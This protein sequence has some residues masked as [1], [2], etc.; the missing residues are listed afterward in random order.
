MFAKSLKSSGFDWTIASGGLRLYQPHSMLLINMWYLTRSSIE[1]VQFLSIKF[2]QHMNE[3]YIL[4]QPHAWLDC[5]CVRSACS[6]AHIRAFWCPDECPYAVSCD[7]CAWMCV[8]KFRTDSDGPFPGTA[9]DA[10]IYAHPICPCANIGCRRCRMRTAVRPHA[11]CCAPAMHST[12][13]T[14]A[15]TPC[16]CSA[17]RPDALAP[18]A[19]RGSPS[20]WNAL[21]KNHTQ[22]AW[23]R[24]AAVRGASSGSCVWIAFR[25]HCIRMFCLRLAFPAS[26]HSGRPPPGIVY[27]SMDPGIACAAF[28]LHRNDCRPE[29][30]HLRC[31]RWCQ[32]RARFWLGLPSWMHRFSGCR[33]DVNWSV[34]E[35]VAKMF[36]KNCA[37]EKAMDKQMF[38]FDWYERR[39]Q[40]VYNNRID[41][42]KKIVWHR[43]VPMDAEYV[44]G[45]SHLWDNTLW[46]IC[47]W[48]TCISLC[49]RRLSWMCEFVILGNY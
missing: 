22:A 9:A 25:T 38:L 40:N 19:W 5:L 29:Y 43:Q 1:I 2:E 6:S 44:S 13:W 21:R 37:A 47:G 48:I 32:L 35:L 7:L 23:R 16:I 12:P 4:N 20:A 45:D 8:H 24:C 3:W 28:P 49:E 34:A 11:L 46:T 41:T 18:H 39:R 31:C 33:A 17:F 14:L 42:K 10:T 26:R 30:C 15:C 27:A 36:D